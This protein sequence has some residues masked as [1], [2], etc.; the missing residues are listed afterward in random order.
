ML[1]LRLNVIEFSNAKSHEVRAHDGSVEESNFF[2]LSAWEG[3]VGDFGHV[4]EGVE[5]F[6]HGEGDAEDGFAGRFVPAGERS[7]E[8]RRSKVNSEKND[9]DIND[10]LTS[11]DTLK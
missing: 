3:L 5:V 11:T 8:M 6:G 10:I 7:S 4:G 1:G 2:E 9:C